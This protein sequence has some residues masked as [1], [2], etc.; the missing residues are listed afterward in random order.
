MLL[1]AALLIT[2]VDKCDR[3]HLT[4]LVRL[5]VAVDVNP[6]LPRC[7]AQISSL[8]YVAIAQGHRIGASHAG[9]PADQ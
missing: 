9:D 2:A 3:L 6:D 4:H 5:N 8:D 7:A 1:I